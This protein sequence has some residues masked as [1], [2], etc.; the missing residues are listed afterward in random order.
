MFLEA[1]ILLLPAPARDSLITLV[2]LYWQWFK[3][4]FSLDGVTESPREATVCAHE[5]KDDDVFEISDALV[6]PRFVD[7][8]LVNGSPN[9]RFYAGATLRS[10]DGMHV[11]TL[12]VIDKTPDY[13]HH[14]RG[15]IYAIFL[16]LLSS[17]WK[18]AGPRKF[19]LLAQPGFEG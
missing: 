5:I 10:C 15:R 2:D 7:N 3:A 16:P 9:R 17:Y 6:G 12:C 11:G 18:C 4:S 13:S 14:S 8:L 1:P 19:S